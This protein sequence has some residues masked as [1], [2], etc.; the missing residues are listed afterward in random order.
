MGPWNS[1]GTFGYSSVPIFAVERAAE[2]LQLPD[3]TLAIPRL[4]TAPERTQPFIKLLETFG[5]ALI[6]K[7]VAAYNKGKRPAN[8]VLI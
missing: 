1:D 5:G 4:K 3:L 8:T 2:V 7:I 6:E